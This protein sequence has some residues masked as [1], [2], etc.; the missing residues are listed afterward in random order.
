[1]KGKKKAEGAKMVLP[2]WMAS[3]ADMFT[4]LMAFFVLLFAMSN[5]EQDLFE[6]FIVSFNPARADDFINPLD[7]EGGGV[8]AAAGT[9]ILPE[10]E[11]PPP[12][13][14]YGDEGG[15]GED[16]PD[17]WLGGD[18]AQGD[19]V[20][21]M[22]NTFMTYMAEVTAGM[23]GEW[24]YIFDFQEG[25][26]YVRINIEEEVG[27]VLF[28]SGQ[29]RLTIAAIEALDLLGP[30]LRDFAAD[31][32]GIIVEGHTDNL[33]I[34]TAAF[35]SNWTLSGA[36]ASSVVEH[37]VNNWGIDVQM[38]AGLGRGEYFP[39]D[40]NATPEGRAR[41]RRVEIKIFTQEATVGSPVGGWFSIPGTV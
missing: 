13:G 18:A 1:M 14:A 12:A 41:N 25:D 23:D 40:T 4:V 16:D 3:Y 28:N 38:I 35:P 24:G 11:P 26:N 9:Q 21:D 36:R 8:F 17:D 7:P 2:G 29:A 20:G 32:H 6:R 30:L 34:N 31:G 33:P 37:L 22:L 19:T 39:L 10:I 27:G 15:T 5:I